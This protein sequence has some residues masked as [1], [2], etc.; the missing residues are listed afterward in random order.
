MDF[1]V[2]KLKKGLE[3]LEQFD[4]DI[5]VP[6]SWKH[7]DGR[8][9][10]PELEY[11]PPVIT[12]DKEYIDTNY[13]RQ[14]FLEDND[15]LDDNKYS[16]TTIDRYSI[17]NNPD[18]RN[19]TML[20]HNN[21]R[22][23]KYNM[24]KTTIDVKKND[25]EE[26]EDTVD[27][28]ISKVSAPPKT[29]VDKKDEEVVEA[30]CSNLNLFD[31]RCNKWKKIMIICLLLFLVLLFFL[32]IG[33]LLYFFVFSNR[34]SNTQE[35]SVSETIPD[36]LTVENNSGVEIDVLNSGVENENRPMFDGLFGKLFGK[37]EQLKNRSIVKKISSLSPKQER[38]T[39]DIQSSIGKDSVSNSIQ[40]T[41]MDQEQTD[42][43]EDTMKDED[44]KEE[45][46]NM[47][48]EQNA[49]KEDAMK[50]DDLKKESQ[51]NMDEDQTDSKED[52]M[53]DDDLK[54]SQMKM[55]EE[56]NVFKEDAMKDDD[57][58]KESQIKM[59]EEQI[60]AI[61]DTMKD[62]DLKESQMKM[63]EEQ[64]VSI[65]DKMN[66]DDIM[67]ETQMKMDE[68]HIDSIEDAQIDENETK[69]EKINDNS[70]EK[71]IQTKSNTRFHK[72]YGSNITNIKKKDTQ[73]K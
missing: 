15:D 45:T 72:K 51:M 12:I 61:E 55:D 53:K 40:T 64:S 52:T 13:D 65:D 28:P 48:E 38:D 8:V 70:V 27:E 57:P 29:Q 5:E 42:S 66:D 37:D 71:Y 69:E 20:Y 19:K 67:E 56:Q 59:D 7:K 32:L 63:D 73:L 2:E 44:L 14:D 17:G 9:F 58:E 41:N 6:D 33:F 62:D 39:I 21:N 23:D 16:N 43:K 46:L 30:K 24:S 49:S 34:T 3:Q 1:I 36:T 22:G 4:N 68:E 26:H 60:V 18:N 25:N 11:K 50:D 35:T 31:F 10:D 54:E 47:D